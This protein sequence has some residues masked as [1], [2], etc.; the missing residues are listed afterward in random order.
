MI[1]LIDTEGSN[2]CHQSTVIGDVSDDISTSGS[3]ASDDHF[4][5]RSDDEYFQD[6]GI[7]INNY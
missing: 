7:A 5:L 6:S 3:D 1:A 2:F 4:R